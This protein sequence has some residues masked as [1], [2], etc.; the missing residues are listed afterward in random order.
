MSNSV[1]DKKYIVD[2]YNEINNK[3]S[4]L[5]TARKQICFY[6]FS[7]TFSFRFHTS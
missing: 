5:E 3:I 4:E 7:C 2:S 6:I 1:L